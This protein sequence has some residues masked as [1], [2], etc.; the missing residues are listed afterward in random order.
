QNAGLKKLFSGKFGRLLH[1]KTSDVDKAENF[2]IK[3][4]RKAVFFGRCI[5]V[6]RSLI[7]IPAGISK[8]N[9]LPF[10]LLTTIGSAIWNTILVWIGVFA[11]DAWQASLVYIGWYTKIV[12][13]VGVV[14]CLILLLVL[15]IKKRK[16]KKNELE[17]HP[18][19][20]DD[21]VL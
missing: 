13:I 2:F 11:G 7:S 12:V 15:F 16:K 17:N 20:D 4:E 1:L 10:I 21:E 19:K 3:Y 6:I 9:F 14:L 8:M 18:P 5:P